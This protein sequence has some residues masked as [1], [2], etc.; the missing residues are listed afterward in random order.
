MK[1]QERWCGDQRNTAGAGAH[2]LHRSNM[3]SV[4]GSTHGEKREGVNLKV[5]KGHF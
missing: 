1:K 4:A 3:Q 2:L 5:T